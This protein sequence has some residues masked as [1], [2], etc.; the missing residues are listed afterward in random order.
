MIN[1]KYRKEQEQK[2]HLFTLNEKLNKALKRSNLKIAEVKEKYKEKFSRNCYYCNN[3]L[4]MT[5]PLSTSLE[6]ITIT[7][8]NDMSFVE[9]GNQ[10]PEDEDTPYGATE[11][12]NILDNL[13]VEES[14]PQT[15]SDKKRSIVE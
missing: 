6:Q 10:Q 2:E 1:A 15:E 11:G 14:N 9:G 7:N 5:A 13:L 12:G 3:E 4:E 8:V